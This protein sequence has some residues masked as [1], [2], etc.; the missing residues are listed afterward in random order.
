MNNNYKFLFNYFVT[1]KSISINNLDRDL[2][3]LNIR[4]NDKKSIIELYKN[5]INTYIQ[6]NKFTKNDLTYINQSNFFNNLSI[7]FL[8][9]IY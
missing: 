6:K 1:K 9:N 2:D 3:L 8:I 5:D 7:N 4:D